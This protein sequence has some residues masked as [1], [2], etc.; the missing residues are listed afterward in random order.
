[1]SLSRSVLSVCTRIQRRLLLSSREAQHLFGVQCLFVSCFCVL[2][3]GQLH[4]LFSFLDSEVAQGTLSWWKRA[5]R[6]RELKFSHSSSTCSY[7]KTQSMPQDQVQS[8][9]GENTSGHHEAMTRPRLI[10]YKTAGNCV[11]YRDLSL[12]F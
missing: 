1:M 4:G 11:S 12:N 9:D 5:G 10:N 3:P 7:P 2:H 6:T 8:Q